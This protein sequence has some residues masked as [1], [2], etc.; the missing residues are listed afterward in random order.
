[1]GLSRTVFLIND[2][3]LHIF[4]P[5]VLNA[6]AEGVPLGIY[7]SRGRAQET[8]MMPHQNVKSVMICPFILTQYRH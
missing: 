5:L 2:K 6:P 4:H 3:S 8:R 1:M 7:Y